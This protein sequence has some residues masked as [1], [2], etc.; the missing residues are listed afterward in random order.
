MLDILNLLQM[1]LIGKFSKL[2]SYFQTGSYEEMMDAID[3]YPAI[4]V[5]DLE[6]M[7]NGRANDT[8]KLLAQIVHMK[9]PAKKDP[10]KNFLL[11]DAKNWRGKAIEKSFTVDTNA[12]M[13]LLRWVS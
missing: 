6:S 7:P 10:K 1:A 9:K 11:T 5:E 8:V 2:G 13:V 3:M 12:R 4:Q